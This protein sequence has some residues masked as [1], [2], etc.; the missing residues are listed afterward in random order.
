MKTMIK[1]APVIGVVALL[2]AC[3]Q[4]MEQRAATG[5]LGGAVA[6]QVLGGNTGSTVAG[7]AIG[8]VGGAATTPR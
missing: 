1:L 8:A 6:G 5:A 3:G 4:T 7:A 2:A